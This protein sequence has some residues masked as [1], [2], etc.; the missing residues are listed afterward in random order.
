MFFRLCIDLRWDNRRRFGLWDL[1]RLDFDARNAAPIHFHYGEA[2]TFGFEAFSATRNKTEPI[3]NEAADGFV[4]GIVGEYD[5]VTGSELANFERGVEDHGPVGKRERP[6]NDIELI[7][8]F[9]DHL[10][11]DVF[12]RGEAEDAAEFVDYHGEAGATRAKFDEQIAGGFCFGHDEHVAQERAEAKFGG[13]QAL[14][15]TAGA[16]Q[17]DPDE[18]FDVDEAENVVEG[19]FVDGNAR[20]LGDTDHGHC[21]FECGR[22]RQGVNVWARNHNF[23][24]LNL[25]ELH[26][27]LNEFHFAGVDEAAFPRLLHQDLKLFDRANQSVAGRRSDTEQTNEFSGDEIEC[28]DGPAEGVQKPFERAS[29]DER[30]SFGAGK[31]E[32]LGDQLTQ[33]DFEAGEKGEGDNQSDAVSNNRGPGAGDLSDQG[34]D[35]VR[36][37]DF[38]DIAQEQAD[39]CDADLNAGDDAIEI[40]EKRFDDFRASVSF[41]D[42]LMDTRGANGDK[43]KLCGRKEG[44]D[45]DKQDDAGKMEGNHGAAALTC[46]SKGASVVAGAKDYRGNGLWAAMAALTAAD[47]PR[48]MVR[49]V[50]LSVAKW[51]A[52]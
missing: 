38:A 22:D 9:A 18:V 3:E 48:G 36:E 29:D 44:V 52:R 13:G 30:D 34:A 39:N 40:G 24:H 31:T 11:E 7:M 46:T 42:E 15:G 26:R 47:C 32:S 25:A 8:N 12:E 33:N 23:A 16:I 49:L 1:Q 41:F 10:F 20:A 21:L 45:E 4:A 17:E 6:F 51:R 5:V 2:V 14:F 27:R 19:A 50:Q 43:R 28:V 37:R 35:D